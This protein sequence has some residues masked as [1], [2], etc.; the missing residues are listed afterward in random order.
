MYPDIY[1]FSVCLYV[2]YVY[3]FLAS[4]FRCVYVCTVVAISAYLVEHLDRWAV[5]SDGWLAL[6]C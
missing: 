1:C 5:W 3:L 2:W 6:L 4:Y